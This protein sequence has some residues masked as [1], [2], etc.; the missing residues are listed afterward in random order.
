MKFSIGN[1]DDENIDS[2]PPFQKYSIWYDCNPY[3]TKWKYSIQ[4]SILLAMIIAWLFALVYTCTHKIETPPLYSVVTKRKINRPLTMI[5]FGDSLIQKAAEKYGL[6]NKIKD[7]LPGFIVTNSGNNGEHIEELRHRMH[8]EV[9]NLKP[10]VVFLF[11]DSDM[12]GM[13][14]T[15]T[16]AQREKVLSNY[17]M[18]VKEVIYA[19]KNVTYVIVSGPTLASEGPFIK[20]VRFFQRQPILE[21]FLELNK[22]ICAETNVTYLD[23][24][25]SLKRVIPKAWMFYKSFVTADGEHENHRGSVIIADALAEAV[26]VWL[27]F[28]DY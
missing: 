4:V 20:P 24:H 5:L 9:L 10:D 1:Q 8:K 22:K 18:K 2:N 27:K 19:L 3:G 6:V 7:R 16:H 23:L 13:S 12:S 26:G 15:L 14:I 28:K 25:T 21:T 11:W 17:T